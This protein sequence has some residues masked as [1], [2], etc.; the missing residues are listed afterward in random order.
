MA[1]N[2]TLI[3]ASLVLIGMIGAVSS[4]QASC[5]DPWIT[6]LAP[7]VWGHPVRGSGETGEC[8][9][10]LY[11]QRW[12]SKD[13]LRG[14]MQQAKRALDA[15][16]LEFDAANPNIIDDKKYHSRVLLTGNNIGMKGSMPAKN[17]MIDLPNGY[18]FALER[19]C[20]PGFSANGPTAGGGC[21]K[22][23]VN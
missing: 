15:A 3:S 6:E 18:V 12:N 10:N 5:R 14:Q 2:R 20:R 4:A 1:K 16:G 23:G 22:G 13:Q 11:G 7:Q 21:V 17:W 19:R 8:N 9:I